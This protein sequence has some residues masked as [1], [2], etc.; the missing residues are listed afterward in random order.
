M[1]R[2]LHDLPSI[3]LSHVFLYCVFHY[4]SDTV[5]VILMMWNYIKF[6]FIFSDLLYPLTNKG[7]SKERERMERKSEEKRTGSTVIFAFQLLS[8]LIC[9][10]E[11]EMR[12][13]S[14]L[15]V[16]LCFYHVNILPCP[17]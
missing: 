3:Y 1:F 17:V 2:V 14:V 10:S 12:S 15:L 9:Q 11:A 6:K 16:P 4:F 13:D 7:T 5:K 8:D